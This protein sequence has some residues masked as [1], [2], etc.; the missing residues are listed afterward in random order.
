MGEK[1]GIW[2]KTMYYDLKILNDIISRISSNKKRYFS[3]KKFET[4]EK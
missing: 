2:E 3:T 1:A 4:Y